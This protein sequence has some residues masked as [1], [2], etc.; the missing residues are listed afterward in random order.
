MAGIAG[1]GAG[2][3]GG[4]W[5]GMALLA[6]LAL[7][8]PPAVAAD[9]PARA[10]PLAARLTQTEKLTLVRADV[11]AGPVEGVSIVTLPGVPRAGLPALRM[12]LLDD[13]AAQRSPLALMATWDRDLARRAGQARARAIRA[14]GRAI[15]SVGGVGPLPA[16]RAYDGEDPLLAGRMMGAV[17][18]GL[19]AGHVLPLF[20]GRGR[21]GA[22][23]VSQDRML[24]LHVALEQARGAGMLC[25]VTVVGAR[26]CG[27]LDGME[28]T[29]RDG[30]HYGG[31]IALLA[32]H[33]TPDGT[34]ARRPMLLSALEAG[35][36]VEGEP[37]TA[38]TALF[39]ATLRQA[40]MKGGFVPPARLDHMAAHV[41]HSMDEAGVTE[42]P[43]PF[44]ALR[45]PALYQDPLAEEVVTEGT[46]LLRN[47]NAIL[48]LAGT[49]ADPILV[50][51]AGAAREAADVMADALNR[52]GQVA[53][54]AADMPADGPLPSYIAQ[55]SHTVLFS[56]GP[57]DDRLISAVAD[58]GGHVVV[59]LLSDDPARPMPWL[60]QVDGVV[61]AWSWRDGGGDALAALLTGQRD[62]SGRLPVTFTGGASPPQ[63]HM[64]AYKAFDRAH[65]APLFPFGYGLS[66]RA[67]FAYGDLKVTR[68]GSRL[69]VGFSVSNRGTMA[70][71][72]VPQI[73][74]DL[75]EG[76]GGAPKRLIGWRGVQLTPGQAARLAVGI[77]AR[78]LGHW[79]P[80][81][82]EWVVPAGE[83]GVSLG[84]H[85]AN[86]GHQVTL[87]L[88]EMHV[89]GAL[90]DAEGG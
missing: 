82:L 40:V 36:D 84:A 77:D 89:P 70:G 9:R 56:A 26:P 52:A 51:G 20:G 16:D 55:A 39:G 22:D 76:A 79:N 28:R 45:A 43:P 23:G 68:D 85:S 50:L 48:P 14:G 86:L 8:A 80:A 37:G 15:T 64:A 83:Y 62:F 71:R 33:P 53:R 13:G 27:G 2:R 65:V 54:R 49:T 78:M 63:A 67:R 12:A 25:H 18:S 11:V 35:I 81:T 21:P 74:L 59:V 19:I 1:G 34:A 4:P 31:M 57:E 61:Q 44:G 69:L 3:A 5:R 60:D 47:E 29:L 73:Y 66:A 58:T 32:D 87:H 46:V 72:D 10:A 6:A 17:A 7:S 42:N 88:P 90:P 30:W 75:P 24:A 41:M 38:D